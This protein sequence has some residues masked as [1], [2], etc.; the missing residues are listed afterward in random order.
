MDSK[1][2]YLSILAVIA[3]VYAQPDLSRAHYPNPQDNPDECGRG[4]KRS[5][6]CDPDKILNPGEGKL[7]LY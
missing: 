3:T 5:Y 7:Y 2:F 1:I 4:D 6:L